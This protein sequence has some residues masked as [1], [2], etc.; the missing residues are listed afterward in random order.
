MRSFSGL[1]DEN[2]VELA[3]QGD[4]DA[5]AASIILPA[6]TATTSPRKA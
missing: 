2:L 4:V 6:E 3:Q 5:K 1:T